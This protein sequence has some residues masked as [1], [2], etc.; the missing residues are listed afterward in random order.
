[1][2]QVRDDRSGGNAPLQGKLEG[3]LGIVP[4]KKLTNI[5]GSLFWCLRA[6]LE[7]MEATIHPCLQPPKSNCKLSSDIK[8]TN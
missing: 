6:V 2:N 3:G 4:T 7:V 5:L 8:T 1:V